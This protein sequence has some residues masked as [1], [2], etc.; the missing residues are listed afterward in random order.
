MTWSITTLIVLSVPALFTRSPPLTNVPTPDV[1]VTPVSVWKSQTPPNRLLNT[2]PLFKRTSP[3]VSDCVITPALFTVNA[4]SVT[5]VPSVSVTVCVD[6][7]SQI[8][9]GEFVPVLPLKTLKLTPFITRLFT[10][11][12]SPV[13]T[14]PCLSISIVTFSDSVTLLSSRPPSIRKLLLVMFRSPG[15]PPKSS[16]IA[17]S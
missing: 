3:A 12:V 4:F 13:D 2:V 11:K 10:D 17:P 16:N 15:P 9:A 8:P 1:R 6:P 5:S 14:V 7:I